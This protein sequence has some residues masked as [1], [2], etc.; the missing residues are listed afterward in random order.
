[1]TTSPTSQRLRHYQRVAIAMLIIVGLIN[2]LDR[3]ALA[4]ANPL[5]RREFGL[6]PAQMGWLLSAFLWAYAAGQ[7]PMGLLSD[8]FGARRV[9]GGGLVV[10]SA[11]QALA[12]LS[13]GLG[14]FFGLR[15]LLGVGEAPMVPSATQVVR[16]WFPVRSRGLPQ[17]LFSS[18][19]SLGA[20]IALPILT[21]LM[22]EFSWR[23]MFML[24]GGVGLL[25]AIAWFACYRAPS[26]AGLSE[27]ETRELAEGSDPRGTGR[28][29]LAEWRGLFRHR[30]TWGIML[31]FASMSY[32]D[33][34][35]RT[36]L[37]SYLQMERHLSIA[38]TGGVAMIPYTLAVF[39]GVSGGVITDMLTRRGVSQIRA[40]KIPIV[41]G[42]VGTGLFTALAAVSTTTF[43]A[44]TCISLAMYLGHIAAPPAF[45]LCALMVRRSA[46]ASMCSLQNA[47][48]YVGG[49]VAPVVTGYIVQATGSF[50]VAL[51]VAA[52]MGLLAAIF[53]WF[54][55]RRPVLEPAE[56]T[57]A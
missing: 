8:R 26:T 55:A 38:E 43:S 10:W 12:G 47:S 24:M 56:L 49:A 2:Y 20:A 33:A 45:L 22:L 4:V 31:G 7:L 11:A 3:S 39:G 52:P 27:A 30:V 15:L 25:A 41:V 37:P 44:V 18:S 19:F 32:V 17:G 51:M 35:F 1:M 21:F 34:L 54:V 46:V 50:F 40:A 5:I 28:I 9:L 29:T 57:A 42:V 53:Y 23:I 6:S 13:G 14:Q 16:D 48:G 36:W